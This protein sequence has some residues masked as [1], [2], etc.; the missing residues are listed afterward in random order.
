MSTRA[1]IA[2]IDPGDLAPTPHWSVWREELRTTQQGKQRLTKVPY[3]GHALLEPVPRQ[4]RAKANDPTTWA[5]RAEAEAAA[6]IL[7]ELAPPEF[8]VGVGFMLGDLGNGISVGGV[9]LDSCRDLETSASRAGPPSWC[10]RWTPMP[11]C[12]RHKRA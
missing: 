2:S 8:R 3:D 4:R 7:R 12:R 1:R 10:A 9:D 11:K 5:T 6:R